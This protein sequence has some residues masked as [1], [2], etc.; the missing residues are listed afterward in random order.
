MGIETFHIRSKIIL[1]NLLTSQITGEYNKT[2]I[3]NILHFQEIF[4]QNI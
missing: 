4:C 3:K 2:L 1:A